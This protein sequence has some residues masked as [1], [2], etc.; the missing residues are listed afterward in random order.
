MASATNGLVPTRAFLASADDV[1]RLMV[2]L[3]RS[4][5][6]PQ[7]LPPTSSSSA[8]LTHPRLRAPRRRRAACRR[9]ATAV[10][11]SPSPS[12][13]T[14]CCPLGAARPLCVARLADYAVSDASR[15]Y[16][17]LVAEF[18]CA[19]SSRKRAAA[20]SSCWPPAS[21]R[22][23]LRPP[24]PLLLQPH[25]RLAH[26]SNRG[27]LGVEYYGS[28][29]TVNILPVGVDMAQLSSVVAAPEALAT[30]RDLSLAFKDRVV[31]LGSTTSTSSRASAS[32]SSPWSGSSRSALSSVAARARPDRQPSAQPR[33]RRR[34]GGRR[35]R[36][37]IRRI[38]A[39]FGRHRYDPIVLV[40][41]PCRPSRRPPTT[42]PPSASSSAPSTTASTSSL[43]LHRLPRAPRFDQ[44]FAETAATSSS[45]SSSNGR[46][47]RSALSSSRHPLPVATERGGR[48]LLPHHAPL[49]LHP[50]AHQVFDLCPQ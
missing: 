7:R 12:S 25:A 10:S 15:D 29:V 13:P 26:Q 41:H 45:S 28:T 40:D 47:W 22:P 33:P 18:A 24:L 9:N 43:H 37:I 1:A 50:S 3:G 19:A 32:S 49:L 23:Q 20:R 46:T 44:A 31:L 42:P 17:R 34:G 38:N 5:R 11:S 4:R 35:G 14:T 21:R 48:R 36:S 8:S 27:H 2:E 39:R 16:R 6:L 30:L